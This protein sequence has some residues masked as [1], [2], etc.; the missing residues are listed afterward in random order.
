MKLKHNCSECKLNTNFLMSLFQSVIA[1]VLLSPYSLCL[2]L[3]MCI[4]CI[5]SRKEQKNAEK[6]F[7]LNLNFIIPSFFAQQ[8]LDLRAICCLFHLVKIK[9]YS[10]PDITNAL[11]NQLGQKLNGNWWKDSWVIKYFFYIACLV[12]T[13][14]EVN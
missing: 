6:N 12:Y 8:T 10:K 13:G 1:L 5:C 2:F 4:R 9:I 3:M 7:F 11:L 14:L